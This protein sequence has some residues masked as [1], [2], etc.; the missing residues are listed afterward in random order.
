M[1][2]MSSTNLEV[3]EVVPFTGALKKLEKH[4]SMQLAKLRFTETLI[5]NARA[6]ILEVP[7][8]ILKMEPRIKEL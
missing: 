7:S 8:Y 2:K 5:D 4:S 3:A 6:L 1:A